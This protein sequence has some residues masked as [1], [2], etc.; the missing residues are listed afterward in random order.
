MKFISFIFSKKCVF[1]NFRE[2]VKGTTDRISHEEDPGKD[3]NKEKL[4]RSYQ[5]SYPTDQ[6]FK[7]PRE[8]VV[9]LVKRKALEKLQI[10]KCEKCTFHS[11]Y[12]KSL[13]RHSIKRKHINEI[14]NRKRK[15]VKFFICEKCFYISQY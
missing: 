7:L 3:N 15:N 9:C 12:K 1:I 10:Y 5:F 4:F 13:K 6:K 8:L 2:I 14:L 11:K